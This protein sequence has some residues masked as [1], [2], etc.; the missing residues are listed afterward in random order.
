VGDVGKV[1]DG[2]AE[3]EIGGTLLGISPGAID[4]VLLKDPEIIV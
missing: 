4:G 3:K 1:L 2:N